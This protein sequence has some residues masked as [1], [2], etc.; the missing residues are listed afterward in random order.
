MGKIFLDFDGP[1]LDNR[2]KYYY[3][4]KSLL[5]GIQHQLLSEEQYWN[6]KRRKVPE[7]KILEGLIS[8]EQIA[9]YEQQR[10]ESIELF[11]YLKMD[12][13]QP[14]IMDT[15]SRW[16]ASHDIFLVTLRKKRESLIQQLNYFG[17]TPFFK[18]ILNENNNTGEWQVK[19]K[20]IRAEVA[21]PDECAMIGDTEVDIATGK[22]FRIKTIAVTSGIR[23]HEFLAALQPDYLFEHIKDIDIDLI[24]PRT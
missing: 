8:I 14:D 12:S 6:V 3:I 15:L 21:N 11:D 9:Q 4:Y 19:E 24:L 1:V 16:A 23:S 13:L 20:L 5:N 17:L 18:K 2:E 22:H 10:L 7:R